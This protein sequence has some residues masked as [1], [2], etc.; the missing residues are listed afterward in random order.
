MF[1]KSIYKYSKYTTKNISR[2]STI[3]FPK[4]YPMIPDNTIWQSVANEGNTSRAKYESCDIYKSINPILFD[5]SLRDGIQNAE[6]SEWTTDRKKHVLR[7]IAQ[8]E[9][10]MSMEVGSLVS[11]KVL[12]ILGD[13]LQLYKH[14]IDTL[15]Q[16][17]VYI[18]MLVPSLNRLYN[19][20]NY[21]IANMSFITS[22]SNAFQLKNTNRTLEETKKE[23]KQIDTLVN[24][25]MTIRKKLYISCITECP[26]AGKQNMTDVIQEVLMYHVNYNFDEL[27]LSDTCGTMTIDEY[28]YLLDELLMSG[29]PASKISL[30]LHV[31]DQNLENIRRILWYS[32]DKNVNRF[33]VS[34]V[35]TGGCSVTMRKDKLLPNL[36]YDLFY[37][38]LDRYILYQL[39]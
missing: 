23:L 17:G 37:R 14:G 1:V 4:Y 34:M 29:V 31:S 38:I 22:V 15:S 36:S 39:S 19:A 10:P 21:N 3:V 24:E 20:L 16:N 2:F 30:H 32:F 5:V 28:E 18:Y 27:C 7:H 33:D 25:T 26:I 6:V 8:T 11:N 13:S 35:E 9:H 12:P